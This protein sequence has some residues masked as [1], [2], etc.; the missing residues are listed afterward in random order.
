MKNKHL[1]VTLI[2]LSVLGL[3]SLWILHFDYSFK[4]IIALCLGGLLIGILINLIN[5]YAIPTKWAFKNRFGING[6]IVLV[7]YIIISPLWTGHA[8]S[9]QALLVGFVFGFFILGFLF[10]S[11]YSTAISKKSFDKSL[12]DDEII[13]DFCFTNEN[14]K[15]VEGIL[16]LTNN[17]RIMFIPLDFEKPLFNFDLFELKKA[18]LQRK[19]GLPNGIIIN[20]NIN[21]SVSYPRLWIK[22]INGASHC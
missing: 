17:K 10:K 2:V 6:V 4:S 9:I 18:K 11:N 8:I 13:S 1:A 15:N 21:I 3:F 22:E 16:I 12:L 19:F 5:G 7:F 20:D 14:V